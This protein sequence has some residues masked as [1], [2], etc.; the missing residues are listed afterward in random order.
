MRRRPS[1]SIVGFCVAVIVLVAIV[2][3]LA[4]FDCAWLEPQWVL[5]PDEVSVVVE[6]PVAPAD[7]QP[8]PLLSLA[9]SR[10]PPL[11]PLS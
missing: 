5:L 9:P 10:A 4:T 6:H 2:P 7:E 1:R 3:G 8:V 11:A